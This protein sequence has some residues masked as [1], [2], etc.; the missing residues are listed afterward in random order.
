MICGVVLGPMR[1]LA[2]LAR[3]DCRPVASFVPVSI[4][5]IKQLLITRITIGLKHP[6][7]KNGRLLVEMIQKRPTCG[8]NGIVGAHMGDGTK[9]V[10]PAKA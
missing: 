2:N 6:I 5:P 8:Y 1:G 10:L 7:D 9:T 4:E 3:T